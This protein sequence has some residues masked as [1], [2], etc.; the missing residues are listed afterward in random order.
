M[1][2]KK[3]E[4]IVWPVYFDA[5]LPRRL[6]RKVPLNEA[7]RNPTINDILK[8]CK[9]LELECEVNEEAKYPRAWYLHR[10]YV[11]IKF[12]GSKS[13]LLHILAK[14]INQIRSHESTSI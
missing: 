4:Y 12:S 2:R 9:E 6:G 8:A 3:G 13:K 14:K 1:E 7:I 5:S 11:R 10:G